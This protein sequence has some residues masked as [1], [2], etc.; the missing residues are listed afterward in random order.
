VLKRND[1][2]PADALRDPEWTKS[3]LLEAARLEFS[4]HGLSGARVNAIAARAGVNKQ[5]LYYYFSDKE[6]LYAE[7]LE[8]AYAEIRVGEQELDLA[9]LPPR[10]AMRR[11]IEFTFDYLVEHRYFVALLNDE[12]VHK[13]RHITN[14]RQIRG[15]HQRLRKTIGNTL[16]RGF[17]DGTF[18]RRVDPI[19]LYISI[20]SLCYFYHSNNYT[21]SAIF[22]RDLSVPAQI[23]RRRQ[24]IIEL[25][26]GYLSSADV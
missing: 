19:D 3:Q 20:A 1:R 13:A 8:R 16:D 17:A 10:A 12:N 2:R 22:G 14:S 25:V 23:K 9:S 26:M 18:K 7:V 5:L 15:L 6:T 24:H 11:F 4:E 21:L